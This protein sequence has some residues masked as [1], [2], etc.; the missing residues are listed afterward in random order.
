MSESKIRIGITHGD[1]N[2]IG[3]EVLIKALSDPRMC[4]LC[5]PV[6]YGSSKVANY[7]KKQIESAEGFNFTLVNSAR[8]A[9]SKRIN[10]I[11]CV[12][13]DLRVEPG[14]LSPAAGEASVAALMAAAEDLKQGTLDAV[15]TAPICKE[16]VQSDQFRYTG[17]TEFFASTFGGDP[18]MM[19]CSDLMKVG[20][21]TIH[22]PISAVSAEI[23]REKIITKLQELRTSLI[24]DFSIREP[25]IAVLSLNPHAG[26]GGL[27]GKEEQEILTPA[28][29]EAVQQHKILAF[30]PF[31]ADGFFA[32][33][34]YQKYD[35]ILAMYH[36]QGLAPFK[37][38][39]CGGV[40]FTA[41]LPIVRTSPAHGVGFDI[42]G[43]NQADESAMRDA[44]YMA[45]D[46]VRSRAIH[47]EITAN[48]L[49]K[50]RRESGADVSV[51]DLPEDPTEKA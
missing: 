30:G 27:I 44:I 49:R 11:N 15:V 1:V 7:Y 22:I 20:L 37:A 19:M 31:P 46:V 39:S 4:E 51:A 32:S 40:N 45:I 41:G 14:T 43:T 17:H 13:D 29:Q 9:S 33:S 3:Y 23:S 34:A 10:L 35:A 38:L 8:E 2:G 18:L 12:S 36:D 5:T 16:N 25:R 24:Q 6:I 47:K 28:I 50:F 21:V 48:P 26:D 42:A